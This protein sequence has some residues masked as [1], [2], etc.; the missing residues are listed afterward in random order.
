MPTVINN[1][2]YSWSMIQLT[3]S[4]LGIGAGDVTLSGV[5]GLKW[6]KKRKIE[7]NYGRGGKAVSRGFGNIVNTAS[8]TM[9]YQTQQDLRGTFG[10]LQ[11]IG[12]FDLIISFAN[13]F[14]AD[15]WTSQNVTLKGCVFDEDAMESSQD[16]TNITHEFNLNPFDIEIETT[17]NV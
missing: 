15:G 5:S 1:V 14:G 4:A 13:E 9:D 8:I 2:A 3:S 16:D 10:S 6:N 11:N 7:N 17:A 12:E